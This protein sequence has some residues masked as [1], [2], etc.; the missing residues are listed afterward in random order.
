MVAFKQPQ[1]LFDNNIT[2]ILNFPLFTYQDWKF[3]DIFVAREG[4]A[5]DEPSNIAAIADKVVRTSVPPESFDETILLETTVTMIKWLDTTDCVKITTE[6]TAGNPTTISAGKVI[7]SGS[8]GVLN[9]YGD[10]TYGVT[11]FFDP[12]TWRKDG[13]ATQ[14]ILPGG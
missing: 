5:D 10:D 7:F 2:S 3:V 4:A 8:A 1:L 12:H 14:S 9:A 11:P 13:G 6:D